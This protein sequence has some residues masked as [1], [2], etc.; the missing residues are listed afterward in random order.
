MSSAW[1][2]QQQYRRL[3]NISPPSSCALVGRRSGEIDYLLL[4]ERLLYILSWVVARGS[5]ARIETQGI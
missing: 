2:P 4:I 3:Q 1:Q 5:L